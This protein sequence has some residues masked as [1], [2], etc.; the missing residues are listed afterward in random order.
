MGQDFDPQYMYCMKSILPRTRTINFTPTTNGMEN[1]NSGWDPVP[2]LVTSYMQSCAGDYGS[3]QFISN[4]VHDYMDPPTEE[5]LRYLLAGIYTMHKSDFFKDDNGNKYNVP[6]GSYAY[7]RKTKKYMESVSV[8][9]STTNPKILNWIKGKSM[10][11]GKLGYLFL[12]STWY[13][14]IKLLRFILWCLI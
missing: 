4:N 6:C 8:S 2:E 11:Q 5:K 9:I 10:I 3:G 7:D 13:H 14:R 1:Y 12:R